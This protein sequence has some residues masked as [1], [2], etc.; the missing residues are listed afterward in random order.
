MPDPIQKTPQ[1]KRPRG[2]AHV[3]R[4]LP[5]TTRKKKK[6]LILVTL[7]KSNDG[8]VSSKDNIFKEKA[9]LKMCF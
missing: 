3:A 7:V 5:C 9:V 4:A 6:G 1:A 2:M 8:S